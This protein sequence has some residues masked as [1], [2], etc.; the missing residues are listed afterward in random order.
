[1][2]VKRKKEADHSRLIG[3]MFNKQRNAH[4]RLILD[5]CNM[6]RSL[7]LSTR[8]LRG[9]GEALNVFSHIFSPGG[10]TN[11][12]LSQSYVLITVPTVGTVDRVYVLR[13]REKVRGL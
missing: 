2:Y 3:G 4:V 8:I 12:L 7:H 5:S 9:C 11:A 6:S 10:L 13:T 1:M